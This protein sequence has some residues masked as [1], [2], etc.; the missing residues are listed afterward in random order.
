MRTQGKDTWFKARYNWSEVFE[1]LD[2]NSLR[3]LI[4]TIWRYAKDGSEPTDLPPDLKFAW[5]LIKGELDQDSFYRECGRL[6]GNP[7]L[8][9][10][11]PSRDVKGGLKGG[12]KKR[13]EEIRKEKEE[14]R[15]EENIGA[16]EGSSKASEGGTPH[17]FTPPTV[18]DV[19]QYCQ[20]RKNGIDPE[21]FIDYYQTRGW[22]LKPGQRM[23][24]WKACI[25]TWERNQKGVRN[26]TSAGNSKNDRIPG[27]RDGYEF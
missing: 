20:E 14:I 22:Y 16:S 4:L 25:R 6:G 13:E 7:H 8:K 2:N 1:E 10:S 26:G 3:I 11:T 18:E 23:K 5:K 27:Q 19:R 15:E 12:S 24:D 17:K 9:S 21:H